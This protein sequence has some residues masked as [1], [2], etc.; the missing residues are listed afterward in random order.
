MSRSLSKFEQIR[1]LMRGAESLRSFNERFDKIT[2]KPSCDK[3][4]FGF[5]EDDR[6]TEFRALVKFSS[7]KGYYGNSSCST[8]GVQITD[9]EAQKY[10]VGALNKLQKEV[11]ATMA[12]LMQADAVN[13]KEAA[14]GELRAMQESLNKL[15]QPEDLDKH[16]AA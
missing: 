7:W 9:D 11:F 2:S 13:L 4:G 5:N 16:E 10:L 15:D 1:S 12:D 6:F 14:E 8:V 3:H